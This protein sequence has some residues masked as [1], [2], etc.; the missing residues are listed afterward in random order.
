MCRAGYKG[1]HGHFDVPEEILQQMN[2][3]YMQITV[4]DYDGNKRLK[5]AKEWEK[6]R[7]KTKIDCQKE[8]I[9]LTNRT[10]T[11]YGWNPPDGWL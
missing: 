2:A 10:I 8:F 11:M 6:L 9:K 4:G 5:C 1:K 7:N 3:L